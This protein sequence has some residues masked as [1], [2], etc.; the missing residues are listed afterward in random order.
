MFI[1]FS[2]QPW[3]MGL[4]VKTDEGK[5]APQIALLESFVNLLDFF[6]FSF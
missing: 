6:F 1:Y 2:K 4:L 3:L 5:S